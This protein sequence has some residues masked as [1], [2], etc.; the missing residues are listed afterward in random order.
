MKIAVKFISPDDSGFKPALC[1]L[2]TKWVSCVVIDYPV[3]VVQLEAKEWPRLR[4]VPAPGRVMDN[5]PI[6]RCLKLMRKAGRKNG[7]TQAASELLDRAANGGE[8]EP[9]EAKSSKPPEVTTAKEPQGRS[10]V[11]ASICQR[12][13]IEPTLARRKL[14]AAGLR[15][16][17]DDAK[18]I[19]S[20][21]SN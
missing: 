3:R 18:K 13:N 9:V 16:P 6:D 21:L 1:S 20:I 11:L 5:Y 2:G 12:L 10:T 14:R 8:E 7:I 17:Y 15:A 19:E 4:D